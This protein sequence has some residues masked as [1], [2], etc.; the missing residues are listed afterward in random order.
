[1]YLKDEKVVMHVVTSRSTH[2]FSLYMVGFLVSNSYMKSWDSA[3]G[4]PTGYGL[5]DRG[6]AVRVPVT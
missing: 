3:V 2:F 5:G 4:L 1:M 6:V